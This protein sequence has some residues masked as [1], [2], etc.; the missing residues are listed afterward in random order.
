MSPIINCELLNFHPAAVSYG[1]FLSRGEGDTNASLQVPAGA[2]ASGFSV[3]HTPSSR[4]SQ[5]LKTHNP[6]RSSGTLFLRP[7]LSVPMVA[8]SLSRARGVNLLALPAAGPRH[9]TRASARGREAGKP[10]SRAAGP[11]PAPGIRGAPGAQ[12]ARPQREISAW[13][14]GATRGRAQPHSRSRA[15]RGPTVLAVPAGD[16]DSEPPTPGTEAWSPG[17]GSIPDPAPAPPVGLQD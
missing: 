15:A 9:T 1:T 10:G 16:P 12:P 2:E 4:A 6:S 13:G 14:A 7:R 3:L 8:R 5:S 17:W 11:A